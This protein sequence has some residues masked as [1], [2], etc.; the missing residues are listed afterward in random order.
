MNIS[1]KYSKKFLYPNRLNPC[2]VTGKDYKW[3]NKGGDGWNDGCRLYDD[4]ALQSRSSVAR[5]VAG[6]II[7][8]AQV[9]N[10]FV[11]H[12]SFSNHG[13][14]SRQRNLIV[15]NGSFCFA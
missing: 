8:L 1:L 14:R 9:V 13:V 10:P 2:E 5:R 15:Y 7:S 11:D 12:K 6:D 3:D 4:A